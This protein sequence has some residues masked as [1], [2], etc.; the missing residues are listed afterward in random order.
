MPSYRRSRRRRRCPLPETPLERIEQGEG[1]ER[2]LQD[3]LDRSHLAYLFLDQKPLT[4]PTHHRASI[5]R[6]DFLVAVDG[7]GTVAVDAKAFI[8]G[9]FVLDA[10]ERRRLDGFETAFNIP[11]WYACFPPAEPRL[12]YLFRNRALMGAGV[13]HYPARQIIRA[14]LA[15]GLAVEHT[16][17]NFALALLRA[18]APALAACVSKLHL[19]HSLEGDLAGLVRSSVAVDE[20]AF[21]EFFVHRIDGLHQLG[22][23]GFVE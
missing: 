18:D 4:I 6:P 7:M 10:A 23:L 8:D 1:G 11:V 21:P 19:R 3:W 12:C 14:P 15:M 20:G 22:I 9:C 2:A 13:S 5:K 17:M 16:N